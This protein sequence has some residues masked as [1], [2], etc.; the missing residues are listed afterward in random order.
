M[1]CAEV[2][3]LVL[4]GSLKFP[5]P[6]TTQMRKEIHLPIKKEFHNLNKRRDRLKKEKQMNK[7]R[8][9]TFT[10]SKLSFNA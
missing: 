3:W 6:C 5:N 9:G 7:K 2:D 10:K 1:R 4:S 8:I